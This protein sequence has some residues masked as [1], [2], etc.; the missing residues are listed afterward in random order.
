MKRVEVNIRGRVQGVS[1]R[2]Y[3]QREAKQL[4]LTG[5]VRNENDGSVSVVAE[6]SEDDLNRLLDFL[7]EG[8]RMAVVE[9]VS[10]N[11]SPARNEFADFNIRMV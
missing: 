11:W 4:G 9:D 2:Y 6:G 3:S 5:W 8:P 10:V 1:F 7:R